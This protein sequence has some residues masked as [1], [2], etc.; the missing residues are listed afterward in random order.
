MEIDP[1]NN[2]EDC[3][4]AEATASVSARTCPLLRNIL[5]LPSSPPAYHAPLTSCPSPFPTSPFPTTLPNYRGA[6]DD[7]DAAYFEGCYDDGYDDGEEMTEERRRELIALGF[8][9]D[10][11]DYL[12]HMR[13]LGKGRQLAARVSGD[14]TGGMGGIG[15]GGW[16]GRAAGAWP[17]ASRD[18]SG[19]D[20]GGTA[21]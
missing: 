13:D 7:E 4:S 11:Y 10:G 18:V 20:A 16:M 12:R 8:P 3:Q 6:L 2:N 9:D 17:R 21:L 15:G 1:H 5:R 14:G 19:F